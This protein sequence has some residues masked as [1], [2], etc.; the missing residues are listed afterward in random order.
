MATARATALAVLAATSS[1]AAGL[2]RVDEARGG[3]SRC[4]PA[5]SRTLAKS[6]E[7]R[8]FAWRGEIYGCVYSIGR[9]VNLRCPS[10]G[11]DDCFSS[12][13]PDRVYALAG[14][15]VAYPQ[16]FTN[17]DIGETERRLI[18]TDLRR[19][20]ER[21]SIAP[22]FDRSSPDRPVIEQIVLKRNGSVAWLARGYSLDRDAQTREAYRM[23][24][25]GRVRLDEGPD[26]VKRSLRLR[27]RTLSWLKSGVRRT[28]TLY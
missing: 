18:V 20:R 19:G 28:A 13:Y 6:S 21:R 15:Y 23:D 10:S 5:D 25:R 7:A 3:P 22:V 26:I 16:D 11:P 12:E 4:K 17:P 2:G 14:R 9:R 24:R 1:V 8:V 27:K